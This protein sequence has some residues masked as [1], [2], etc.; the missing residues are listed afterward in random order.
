MRLKIMLDFNKFTNY[1]QE[2]LATSSAIM[3]KYKNPEMQPPH[4]LLAMYQDDGIIR[5]YFNELKLLNQDFA[6]RLMKEISSYPTISNPPSGQMFLS[7]NTAKILENAQEI[8]AQMKDEFVSIEHILL[9]LSKDEN[10]NK[11]LP[12]ESAILNVMKKIRGNKKVDDKNE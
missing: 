7:Q 4:I 2:I 11:F 3:N 6:N 5:D 8:S 10:S 9:A 1:S 12:S